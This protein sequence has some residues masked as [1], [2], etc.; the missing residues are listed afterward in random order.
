[1]GAVISRR[2]AYKP[3]EAAVEEGQDVGVSAPLVVLSCHGVRHSEGFLRAVQREVNN[4]DARGEPQA[5]VVLR[6][7]SR[8]KHQDLLVRRC[9]VLVAVVTPSW[10]QSR[11]AAEDVQTLLSRQE[12]ASKPLAIVPVICEEL[13]KK[14]WSWWTYN[15]AVASLLMTSASGNFKNRTVFL[16]SWNPSAIANAARVVANRAHETWQQDGV[17][18]EQLVSPPE[19]VTSAS[20]SLLATRGSVGFQAT[21]AH[22]AD[23]AA[24]GSSNP[25]VS[26]FDQHDSC[27]SDSAAATLPPLEKK[28]GRQRPERLPVGQH[29]GEVSLTRQ[30]TPNAPQ[31][32]AI[33]HPPGWE[34]QAQGLQ[35]RVSEDRDASQTPRTPT[36]EPGPVLR[37]PLPMF[38][39]G[40]QATPRD[41]STT[42]PSGRMSL[43]GLQRSGQAWSTPVA[44]C[45][46][47]RARFGAPQRP[48]H[49][50]SPDGLPTD[51]C[52]AVGWGSVASRTP[53]SPAEPVTPVQ[54]PGK[55]ISSAVPPLSLPQ[56]QR[57][58]Q[59]EDLKG[60]SPDDQLHRRG[61]VRRRTLTPPRCTLVREEEPPP[62]PPAL[63]ARTDDTM[64]LRTDPPTGKAGLP[65]QRADVPRKP[66]VGATPTG[67]ESDTTPRQQRIWRTKAALGTGPRGHLVAAFDLRTGERYAVRQI[68]LAAGSDGG[69]VGL[70]ELVR[71]LDRVKPL[72]HGG[73]VRFFDAE[74]AAGTVTLFSEL[75]GVSLEVLLREGPQPE[76]EV[77]RVARG[78]LGGLIFLHAHGVCHR[79]L[80]AANIFPRELRQQVKIC[81]FGWETSNM[82]WEPPEMLV[83][84]VEDTPADLWALG[85]VVVAM[86]VGEER[87]APPG[88]RRFDR[89]ECLAG[90][91][92]P[93]I[94]LASAL[95]TLDPLQRPTAAAAA[96]L[97]FFA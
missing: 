80:H 3:A 6:D 24:G 65:Q 53:R 22:A 20:S 84:D 85:V 19:E 60:M 1:M 56:N 25:L 51:S 86:S 35:A 50:D 32:L 26:D 7:L 57:V 43:H 66:I 36:Q 93:V 91:A 52:S 4:T 90:T 78:A 83:G 42:P 29:R 13:L 70:A 62:P 81:D 82:P 44:R 92:S 96:T 30:I 5:Q 31:A 40:S 37:A 68:P 59:G 67:A 73:L 54:A 12:D 23:R 76:H 77:L 10:L 74:W 79:R 27:V 72:R 33:A 8:G 38:G 11:V 41:G 47:A 87:C 17:S 16:G 58:R 28:A 95:L 69:D 55:A 94:G 2:S 21:S 64:A 63:R 89:P 75:C 46:A 39:G 71:V 18:S 48:P 9:Q 34:M 88:R 14:P 61:P 97:D 49:A 45:A 15:N